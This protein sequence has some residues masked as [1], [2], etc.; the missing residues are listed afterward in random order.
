MFLNSIDVAIVQVRA[1]SHPNASKHPDSH[2]ILQYEWEWGI[3]PWDYY[4]NPESIDGKKY[5]TQMKQVLFKQIYGEAKTDD[6]NV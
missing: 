3:D 4:P 2:I 5:L 6:H 1:R